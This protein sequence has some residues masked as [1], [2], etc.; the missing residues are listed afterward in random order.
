MIGQTYQE[1]SRIIA[2]D[3]MGLYRLGVKNL[4]KINLEECKGDYH[5]YF[6]YRKKKHPKMYARLTF[7]TNGFTPYSEDLGDIM[8]DFVTCGFVEPGKIIHLE[9]IEEIKRQFN[10][11]EKKA[12]Q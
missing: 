4:N 10:W 11:R 8:M 9:N 3:L 7:D 1:V 6:Y 12:T 5:D 2:K